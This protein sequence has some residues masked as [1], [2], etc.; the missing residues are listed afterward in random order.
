[1]P[2]NLQKH[3]C[4]GLI[5]QIICSFLF[6]LGFTFYT[7]L[8]V[9]NIETYTL[10]FLSEYLLS[11]D[12][13]KRHHCHITCHRHSQA[14]LATTNFGHF[15]FFGRTKYWF[16]KHIHQS[17]IKH[18]YYLQSGWN[19][20]LEYSRVAGMICSGQ[21]LIFCISKLI[22]IFYKAR[23][24]VRIPSQQHSRDQKK[25][26]IEFHPHRYNDQCIRS[27]TLFMTPSKVYICLL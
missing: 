20:R 11:R 19:L 13:V 9:P 23:S 2:T 6:H 5:T 27:L 16:N 24:S 12:E 26:E 14:E 21:C 17:V 7:S 8:E 15:L 22:F 25:L 10:L 3:K 4:F 1:M 18:Y